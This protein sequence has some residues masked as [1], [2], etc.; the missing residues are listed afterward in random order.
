VQATVNL[1]D[2]ILHVQKAKVSKVTVDA[3]RKA[4]EVSPAKYRITRVEV[5]QA[6]VASG[7]NDI[8]IDN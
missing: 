4:L 5:K 2:V 1:S 7:V 8:W 6:I 3:H